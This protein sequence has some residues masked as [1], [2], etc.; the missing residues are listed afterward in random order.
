MLIK[1]GESGHSCLAPDNRRK[2]FHL[3]PLSITLAL[4]LSYMAFYFVEVCSLNT[5]FAEFFSWRCQGCFVISSVLSHCNKNLKRRT[6][7]CYSP[8]L[9][10]FYL[11]SK[12]KYILEVWGQANPK[13][14]KRR[15]APF[16]ILAPLFMFFFLLPLGLQCV[17]WASQEGCLLYLRSSL[18][19]SDLP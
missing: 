10:R 4:S 17:K 3:S 18:W 16:S 12:G 19:F 13:A 1:R 9:Q 8:L 11:E 2:A 14:T 6:D 5:Q 7:Q 15:E